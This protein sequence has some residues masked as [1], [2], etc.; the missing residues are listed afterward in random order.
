MSNP[1]EHVQTM[2]RQMSDSV[3]KLNK[4]CQDIYDVL[5]QKSKE[6]TSEWTEIRKGYAVPIEEID[7]LVERYENRIKKLQKRVNLSKPYS[8][9]SPDKGRSEEIDEACITVLTEVLKD[10]RQLVP[11]KL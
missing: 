4:T 2:R 3:S 8:G 7:T 5:R 11:E 6:K 10:L 9:P 1:N